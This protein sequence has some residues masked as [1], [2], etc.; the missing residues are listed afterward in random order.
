LGYSIYCQ[1]SPNTQL[2]KFFEKGVWGKNFFIKKFFPQKR[3]PL[4]LCAILEK[5]GQ[6]IA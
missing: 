1:I 6:N 3:S 5:I 4:F 2:Q